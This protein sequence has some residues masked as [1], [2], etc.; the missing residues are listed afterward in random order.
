[1]H[2]VEIAGL[3]WP[4]SQYNFQ[5]FKINKKTKLIYLIDK[6]TA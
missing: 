2:H 4:F 1:M 5:K 6:T 3:A